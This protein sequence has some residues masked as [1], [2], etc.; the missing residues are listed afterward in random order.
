ME[1][2]FE[3]F[4]V[5]E[6]GGRTILRLGGAT[7][8]EGFYDIILAD[9]PW[10][11]DTEASQRGKAEHHYSTMTTREICDLQLQSSDNALLFMWATNAHLFDAK[12]VLDAWGFEYITNYA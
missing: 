12:L 8:P 9:P 5:V 10:R 7:M 2:N 11:Y 3:P 6:E 1:Q 4:E